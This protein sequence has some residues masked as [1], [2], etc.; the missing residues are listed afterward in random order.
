MGLQFLGHIL[1]L[2]RL[3][4]CCLVQSACLWQRTQGGVQ[5]AANLVPSACWDLILVFSYSGSTRHLLL[6]WR[7]LCAHASLTLQVAQGHAGA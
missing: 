5:E 6:H 2:C 7:L 3:H 4:E 1:N